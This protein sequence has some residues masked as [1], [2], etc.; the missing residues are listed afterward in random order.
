MN[1]NFKGN[2]TPPLVDLKYKHLGGGVVAFL[3]THKYNTEYEWQYLKKNSNNWV[4]SGKT[5]DNLFTV[6]TVPTNIGDRYR[7]LLWIGGRVKYISI[8]FVV[9]PNKY[10][11]PNNSNKQKSDYGKSDVM[12]NSKT[13]NM[14][15]FMGCTTWEQVK[16]RYKT[17]MKTYHPDAVAGVEEYSKEINAQYEKQKRKYGQ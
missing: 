13:L 7:C 17:L 10:S 12:G 5:N 14:D 16:D 2:Y 4:C 6:K 11:V 3:V 1:T 9:N 15:F 8:E